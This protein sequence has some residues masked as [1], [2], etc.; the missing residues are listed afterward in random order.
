[1]AVD[2]VD[3]V[4]AQVGELLEAG[5]MVAEEDTEHLKDHLDDPENPEKGFRLAHR[6]F[7][8]EDDQPVTIT[9]ILTSSA[10]VVRAEPT[11]PIFP[12]PLGQRCHLRTKERRIMEANIADPQRRYVFDGEWQNAGDT[13]GVIRLVVTTPA[14][15]DPAE[16]D[17]NVGC[18]VEPLLSNQ[19]NLPLI[20][21]PERFKPQYEGE[22]SFR[23]W[24]NRHTEFVAKFAKGNDKRAKARQD[25]HFSKNSWKI[26]AGKKDDERD[27][28][29][30]GEAV[31]V[32]LMEGDFARVSSVIAALPVVSPIQFAA[33]RYTG[34]RLSFSTSR[35]KYQ[36]YVPFRTG[37]A[38]RSASLFSHFEN[39][40]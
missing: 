11:D 19:G 8:F 9:P 40:G 22:M 3:P 36:V 5:Q 20:V 28:P 23:T 1:M 38:D 31:S 18:L 12:Q 21:H 2:V 26:S 37:A 35:F 25:H 30:K 34:L 6:Q 13:Q 29:G 27:A 10:V 4:I 39:A 33:N 24:R 17:R 7:V 16:C 32:P 14:A 15:A